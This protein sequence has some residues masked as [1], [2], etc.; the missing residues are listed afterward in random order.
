MEKF[1]TTGRDYSVQFKEGFEV[2]DLN[3]LTYHLK[4]MIDNV[5][6]EQDASENS[7]VKMVLDSNHLDYC[8]NLPYIRADLLNSDFVLNEIE[9]VAQSNRTFRLDHG[10]KIKLTITTPP[11]GGTFVR[12][13][14]SSIEQFIMK[15]KV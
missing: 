9:K 2:T 7:Y 13:P 15:K 6:Y 12:N 10:L 1:E 14:Y 3:L 5:L 11:S 8:I 4:N